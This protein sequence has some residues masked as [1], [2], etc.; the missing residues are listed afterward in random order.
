[1]LS[2]IWVGMIALAV[3]YGALAGTLDAVGTAAV[4]GAQ[5]AIELCIAIGGPICLWSGVMALL[6]KGGILARLTGLLRPV[7]ARLFPAI[8][9]EPQ[10]MEPISANVAANMLGLANAAT[11]LGMRAAAA[12]GARSAN[13]VASAE[14]CMLVVLNT[15]SLQLIPTTV[16]AVRAAHG[17]EAPFDILPAAWLAAAASLAVGLTVAIVCERTAQRKARSAK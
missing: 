5:A 15:A 3:G 1:M 10:L 9:R 12:L 6:Q 2:W 16:A 8:C 7:L 4:E 17:A 11:P 13:G 14:L